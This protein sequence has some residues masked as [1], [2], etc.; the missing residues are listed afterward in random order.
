MTDAAV[1]VA[2]A[3]LVLFLALA[4]LAERRLAAVRVQAPASGRRQT[5][6]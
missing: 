4:L 3:V 2:L 5:G 6:R 1:A